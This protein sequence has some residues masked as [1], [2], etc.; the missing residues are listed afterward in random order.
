MNKHLEKYF[1]ETYPKIFSEMYGPV[2][3][4]C[5]HWGIDCGDG[6]FNLLDSL[7]YKIQYRIDN[8]VNDLKSG[9]V[10]QGEFDLIPQVVAKQVKEK[11]GTLHFYYK[12]GDNTINSY[13]EMAESLSAFICE[14]CGLS[15]LSLGST[16]NWIRNLCPKCAKRFMSDDFREDERFV[17]NKK[18]LKL[19]EKVK[20]SKRRRK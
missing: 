6:W 16:T 4:T 10:T 15:D 1:V 8:R 13:I 2:D 7:C 19:L 3:K 5:M 11:F 14:D 20:Q 9:Y 18:K 17:Q 12:G